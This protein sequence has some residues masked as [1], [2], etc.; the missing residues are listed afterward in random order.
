MDRASPGIPR[1]SREAL[2]AARRRARIDAGRPGLT[3]LETA[4][5]RSAERALNVHAS[6]SL[7]EDSGALAKLRSESFASLTEALQRQREGWRAGAPSAIASMHAL[8]DD[9]RT[10]SDVLIASPPGPSYVAISTASEIDFTRGLAAGN[11]NRAPWKNW[12]HL[13]FDSSQADQLEQGHETGLEELS[14]MFLWQNRTSAY[15]VINVTSR[16]GL[17]GGVVLQRSS[18]A[19]GSSSVSV[20][21]DARLR[22]L[23]MWDPSLSEPAFQTSQSAH[24]LSGSLDGGGFLDLGDVAQSPIQTTA[25]VV[26]SQMVVP[27]DG[28][29]IIEVVLSIA[30]AHSDQNSWV[31][32]ECG[33]EFGQ[34]GCPDVQIQY[35]TPPPQN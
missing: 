3:R 24:I 21:L 18:N 11:T 34:V 23:Q 26:Y 28:A 15:A 6:R 29:V 31:T 10:S 25:S 30:Y 7:G 4:T 22:M 32:V 14:F 27:A 35:L 20:D 1:P 12:A 8:W 13:S 9:I 16:L 19:W 2:D 33:G 17:V 5:K